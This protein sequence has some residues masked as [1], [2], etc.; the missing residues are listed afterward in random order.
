MNRQRY[1]LAKFVPDPRRMEPRNV[2]VIL[3]TKHG[4]ALR[5][6]ES[7]GVRH[8]GADRKLYERW[9]TYWKD[10]CQSGEIIL[11]RGEK[12]T[13]D[14]D[15]FLDALADKQRGNFRLYDV[16]RVKE[17][18]TKSDIEH[19]LNTLFEELVSSGTQRQSSQKAAKT[20]ARMCKLIFEETGLLSDSRFVSKKS[21]IKCRIGKARREFPIN[22]LY[23][24][25]NRP[26]ALMHRV[27]LSSEKSIDATSYMFE[28]LVRDHRVDGM[29]KCAALFDPTGPTEP[30]S[31][32][33]EQLSE[34]CVPINV[35]SRELA[36]Q[37]VREVCFG[38]TA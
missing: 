35:S 18:I 34:H 8:L 32:A 27:D 7:S 17:P 3:W 6:L 12:V 10:T 23:G 29:Q 25:V 4:I 11:K 5:F 16:G 13:K 20:L 15:E 37:L 19:V 30:I 38:T 21:L 14:T 9:V 22:Y 26:I 1:L 2:G 24:K 31:G 36:I 28:R 33:I